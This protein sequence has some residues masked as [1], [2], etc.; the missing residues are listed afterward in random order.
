MTTSLFA[1]ES[2]ELYVNSTQGKLHVSVRFY[3]LTVILS[4]PRPGDGHRSRYM[5]R[6][7]S[8]Y[9]NTNISWMSFFP[10]WS[11]I[12]S[13]SLQH[14]TWYGVFQ[15]AYG[16]VWVGKH[17][18]PCRPACTRYSVLHKVTFAKTFHT[19]H[20]GSAHTMGH[21]PTQWGISLL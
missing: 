7:W 6:S 3:V 16:T 20:G 5:E 8:M 15:H 21:Q 19:M 18:V 17:L 9:S 11:W 10:S 12:T 1:G 4:G 14:L 13:K 2:I